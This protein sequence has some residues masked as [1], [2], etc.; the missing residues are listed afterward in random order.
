MKVFADLHHSSLYYSLYL[1][2]EKR[3]NY[4]LYRPIGM[5]WFTQ[6]YWK[7]AD[8][9]DTRQATANQFLGLDHKKW[10]KFKSLNADYTIEDGVYHVYDP[11][12]YFHQKAITLEK[13]KEVKFD[14]I[15]A[16]YIHHV[17]TFARL[18]K[19]YQPQAKLIHQMGN[20]WISSIDFGLVR[21]LMASTKKISLPENINAVWY[22]QEFDREVFTYKPYKPPLTKKKTVCLMNNL[23]AY[24]DA[25]LFFQMEKAMPDW[26]FKYYGA[27]NRDGS[28]AGYK[29]V[30]S[31]IH[32][33]AFVWHCKAGGDGF[34]HVVHNAFACGRPPIVKKEYYKD[35]LAEELMVGGET[36]IAIDNLTLPE[37]IEK[38]LYYSDDIRYQTM[39][40]AA[41][42][43]FCEVVDYNAE[44][45]QLR[46]FMN[47]LI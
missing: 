6:G 3:L 16:S 35:Q 23:Q 40:E 39:S 45:K 36:C 28:L 46:E 26:K 32:D 21:N 20:N 4:E 17:P 13:F 34:G 8:V 29:T 33:S 7:I 44:E 24:P 1:L 15:I 41:Y 5:N 18:V 10:D 30:A 19:E 27:S 47:R 42:K 9:Y 2:F 38:V 14:I 12:N 25:D 43:R 31:E 37:I 11:D 22:H